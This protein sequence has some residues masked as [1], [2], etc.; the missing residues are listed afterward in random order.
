TTLYADSYEI[1]LVDILPYPV[2]TKDISEE[3]VA[4]LSISKNKIGIVLSPLKQSKSGV[5]YDLIYCKSGLVLIMK[6]TNGS[7]ACVKPETKTRL[8]ERGWATDKL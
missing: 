6:N 3:Y 5:K 8:F 7:P 1:N 4:T 2:S